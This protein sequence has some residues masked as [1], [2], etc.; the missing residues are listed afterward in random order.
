MLTDKRKKAVLLLLD[1]SAAFDT[2]PHSTLLRRL[3]HMYGVKGV[4]LDWFRSYLQERKAFVKIGQ[5]QSSEVE[6]C[7]GVPQGSILGPLLF[8]LF[9]K[10]LEAIAARHGVKIHLYA[11]DSQLY[12]S[13]SNN[14]WAQCESQLQNCFTEVEKW[15][16]SSYLKLNPS[17]TELLFI[18]SRTDKSPNPVGYNDTLTLS[19]SSKA[20]I[21]PSQQAK[22]LG[23]IFD[24]RL[25]LKA[26]VSKVVKECNLNLINLR[27]IADKLSRK[28]KVQLVHSLIHSRL[29]YCNGLLIGADQSDISRLQ[30]VQNSATRFIFGRRQRRGVT[31]LRK[32]LHFLPVSARIEFKICL[33]V[34]KCLNNLAPSYLQDIIQRRQPKIKS[35]RHDNDETL[36]ERD[37]STKYKTSQRAFQ[38]S[39]PRLW[40]SLPASIRNCSDEGIFKSRLKTYLFDKSY[41][42]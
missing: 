14:N 35:L 42:H 3:E 15:M 19:Q 41:D 36:L 30:K 31:K 6:I 18:S 38:V 22:N 21:T 17:K 7:I 10:D 37:F 28:H 12:I 33:M 20:D 39:G 40:N 27:R 26:H 9:T 32:Q 24:E 1:L 11:D 5:G 8:V 23:V 4:A 29:D 34:F 16:A 25:T 2:V 13:F